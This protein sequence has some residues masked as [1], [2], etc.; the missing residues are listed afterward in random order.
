MHC[1][2]KYFHLP[3]DFYFFLTYIT[4]KSNYGSTQTKKRS[5]LNQL[6]PFFLFV[7]L[8]ERINIS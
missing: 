5:E 8:P 7:V 2:Q 4:Y 6:T 3:I 1:Q